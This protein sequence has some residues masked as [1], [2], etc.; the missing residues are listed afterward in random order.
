[1]TLFVAVLEVFVFIEVVIW[2][3][4]FVKFVALVSADLGRGGKL[5]LALLRAALLGRRWLVRVV[6]QLPV[7]GLLDGTG[8]GGLQRLLERVVLLALLLGELVGGEAL[9]ELVAGR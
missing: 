1:M 5:H 7:V 8:V 9:H 3:V 6:L 4:D 2:T